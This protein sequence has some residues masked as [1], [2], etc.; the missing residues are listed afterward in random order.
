[1]WN[2]SS[3]LVL[4]SITKIF[5]MVKKVFDQICSHLE[6]CQ[7]VPLRFVF[8][9]AFSMFKNVVKYGI[10]CL[11]YYGNQSTALPKLQIF[12]FSCFTE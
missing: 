2:L 3:Y 12:A 6:V 1:M 5:Q 10:S 11:I 7:N 9:I 8:S 4:N